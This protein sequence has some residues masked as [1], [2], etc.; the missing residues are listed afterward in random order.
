[1]RFFKYI[2]LFTLPILLFINL[3]RLVS[4]N[5]GTAGFSYT[6]EYVST[7]RGWQNTV[8]LFEYM[9]SLGNVDN[10][11][12]GILLVLSPLW[13]PTALA[14]AILGDILYHI[15]FF[16]GWIGTS[17]FGDLLVPRAEPKTLD[18]NQP[19]IPPWDM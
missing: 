15:A 12:E 6:M 10:V 13:A 19:F 8:G 17:I 18:F 9:Y 14:L 16:F 4:G 3:W 5:D 2:L 11:G 7:Y 1:M